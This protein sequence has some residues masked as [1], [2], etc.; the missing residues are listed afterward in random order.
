MLLVL[1]ALLGIANLVVLLTRSVPDGASVEKES[2]VAG[3]LSADTGDINGDGRT[4]LVIIAH[5]RVLVYLQ[6]N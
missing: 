6:E 4:D 2:G 3:D 5:D 1:V